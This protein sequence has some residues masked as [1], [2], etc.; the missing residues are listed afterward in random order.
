MNFS[1]DATENTIEAPR[2]LL[3]AVEALLWAAGEPLNLKKIAAVTGA[4][5]VGEVREAVAKL[6]SRFAAR[7]SA[8]ELVEVAGGLR[9]TTR[10]TY[11]P[12]LQ[13]LFEGPGAGARLSGAAAET[14]AIVAYRQPVVRAEIEAI[15]GVGCGDVL[16]QLLEVDLLR[17]VGRSEEL[18]RPLLYGTTGRFLELYGLGSLEDLPDRGEGDDRRGPTTDNDPAA[19]ATSTLRIA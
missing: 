5:G 8:I 11:A 3:G 19:S 2:N 15:R 6:R 1:D 12:W 9:L 13:R 17:I 18:G 16:R 14:L 7:R 10:P 4:S